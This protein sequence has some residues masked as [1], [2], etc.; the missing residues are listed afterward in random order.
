MSD[1]RLCTMLLESAG[2]PQRS[3]LLIDRE[4]AA[5]PG[6]VKSLFTM[7][8]GEMASPSL[9]S[10]VLIQALGS[11]KPGRAYTAAFIIGRCQAQDPGI[12]SSLTQ[13]L[14]TVIKEVA[15]SDVV[16]E[17]AMSLVLRGNL[18]QGRQT[19]LAQVNSPKPLG[20]QYKA[21]F[22]LAQLG[23]PSGYGALVKTLRS[24]IPHYRLMALRHA[25]AFVP[26]QA[27]KINN[28]DV[29]IR[30]LLIERLSDSD[31]LVR[32]EVPFYLEELQVP[33]L[34]SLLQ[35]VAQYDPSPS[36]RTAAQ[37]VLDRDEV[38]VE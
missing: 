7:G 21:A 1:E 26:Y 24:E 18:E 10:D 19:L 2:L 25:I 3:D 15:E 8:K 31:E 12:N 13:A 16:I 4:K 11:K 5:F 22:Y 28:L 23:D 27:Q 36:V 17:A 34:R 35:P 38:K 9:T 33:D 32:S 6:M 14:E 37:I 29:D 30:G 20:D